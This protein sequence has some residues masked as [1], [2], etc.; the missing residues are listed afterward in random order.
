[1]TFP[2]EFLKHTQYPNCVKIKHVKNRSV[3]VI[4]DEKKGGVFLRFRRAD[5]PISEKNNT[6]CLNKV[7]REKLH[8][9]IVPVSIEA[10][11]ALYACLDN[12]LKEVYNAE[13]S[14]RQVEK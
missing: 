7:F 4:T 1:M 8:E 11:V 14:E 9:T 2:L 13:S 6:Q 12:Y 10:A 3:S 5:V